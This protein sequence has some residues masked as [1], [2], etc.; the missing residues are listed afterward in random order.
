MNLK[1]SWKE[2]R[3][4]LGWKLNRIIMVLFVVFVV[5]GLSMIGWMYRHPVNGAS[6]GKLE[7]LR[8][9]ADQFVL[10]FVL[11]FSIFLLLSI[12]VGI[13]SIRKKPKNWRLVIEDAEKFQKEFG[14]NGA[15]KYWINFV[16]REK[17]GKP[18]F[19]LIT[20]LREIKQL[21][22]QLDKLRANYETTPAQIVDLEMDIRNLKNEIV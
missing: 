4:W 12:V 10:A 15:V 13:I 6:L 2:F 8:T 16:E 19:K 14:E 20:V 9:V 11:F 3:I 18:L 7:V 17:I 1:N 5:I 22:D 21:E